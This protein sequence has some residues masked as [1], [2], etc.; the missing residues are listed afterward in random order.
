MEQAPFQLPEPPQPA[1]TF[2]HTLMGAIRWAVTGAGLG[3][4]FAMFIRR[5][6]RNIAAE[7]VDSAINL[8]VVG[9]IVGF[10]EGVA[11]QHQHGLHAENIALKNTINT[12]ERKMSHVEHVMGD[13]EP[14]PG[15]QI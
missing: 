6:S 5:G 14:A 11:A 2:M 12:L 15:P 7:V 4:V 1:S 9:G 13:K 8:G 3:A 10:T